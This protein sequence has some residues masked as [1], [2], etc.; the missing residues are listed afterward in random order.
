VGG[1]S[2]RLGDPVGVAAAGPRCPQRP[3][4]RPPQPPPSSS[5]C[6]AVAA[7][8]I[9]AAALVDGHP[10]PLPKDRPARFDRCRRR[11]GIARS[12]RHGRPHRSALAGIHVGRASDPAIA[13][14]TPQ[15][16][17]RWLRPR[18]PGRFVEPGAPMRHD[19]PG[20]Q[21]A[22]SLARELGTL[23]ET[24]SAPARDDEQAFRVMQPSL[25]QIAHCSSLGVTTAFP[26]RVSPMSR[27]VRS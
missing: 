14:S 20:A 24:R 8:L 16:V 11:P 17:W 19:A 4:G 15:Y 6:L 27:S 25:P 26:Q 5:A 21:P 13:A 9:S 7:L 2:S 18:S 3:A 12:R 22:L 10:A 1:L 23:A